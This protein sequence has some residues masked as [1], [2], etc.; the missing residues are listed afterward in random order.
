LSPLLL[1]GVAVEIP[2]PAELLVVE[3][4]WMV[5][6]ILVVRDEDMVAAGVDVENVD[7]VSLLALAVEE[8]HEDGALVKSGKEALQPSTLREPMD[9][10]G[11]SVQ[12]FNRAAVR[13]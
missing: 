8:V 4:D 3:V 12:V 11:M 10:P 9:V 1:D 2:G 6:S 13:L 5:L 7:L